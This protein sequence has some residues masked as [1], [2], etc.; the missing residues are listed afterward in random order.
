MRKIDGVLPR[1]IETDKEGRRIEEISKYKEVRGTGKD[2][3]KK[4]VKQK[5]CKGPVEE[6]FPIHWCDT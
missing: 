5:S 3:D 6:T 4:A 2:V 1:K